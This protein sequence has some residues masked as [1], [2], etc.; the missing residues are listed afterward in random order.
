VLI[1]PAPWGDAG[2]QRGKHPTLTLYLSFLILILIKNAG[3]FEYPWISAS[4]ELTLQE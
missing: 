2:R 3:F 4:A 1:S